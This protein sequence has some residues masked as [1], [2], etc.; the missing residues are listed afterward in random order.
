MLGR[1]LDH[2]F[3]QEYAPREIIVVD[4]GSEDETLE[5]A[6]RASQRGELEL[7]RSDRNRGC[8]SARNLGLGHAHGEIVAFIDADG[9]ANERWLGEVVRAFGEDPQVGGVASTVFFDDNPLVL[10]GAGG[11]VNRQGWAADLS[12][13]ESYEHAQLADEALYPMGCGMAVRRSAWERVGPFDD[14]MLNYYDDVDYGTRLWRAGYRVK[15]A[16]DAWIDH[17]AAAGDSARKRLLCERHRMRVVL[18]H[19][20]ARRITRWS[21]EEARSFRAAPLVAR[22]RKLRAATWNV[23]HLPSVLASRWRLRGAAFVP[24][25]LIDASWGDAFPVG[26][27]LRLH[28]DPQRAG[29]GIDMADADAAAQLTHGWFPPELVDGRS[30]R[31]AGPS[32][33][34]LIRLRTPV[35]QLRLDYAHVP[36]DIGGVD[37]CVR[38]SDSAEPLAAVWR[39]CLQ[40]QYIARTVE[41]HPLALA[42]G[43]YEV[44]FSTARGWSEPPRETRS[45]GFAL[46]AIAFLESL[47]ISPGNLDMASPGAE[48]HLVRG[49]FEAEQSAGHS[50]RWS[51]G[52]AALVVR[53]AEV[54]SQVRLRYRMAPAP[55]GDVEVSFTPVGSSRSVAGWQIAWRAGDWHDESFA[56]QLAPGDYVVSFAVATTWSNPGQ[57]DRDLP[58]ENRALGFALSAVAFD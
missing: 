36:V 12:M 27:A 1:C 33:A 54:T 22:L 34:A 35:S 4:D 8:P 25:R 7:L 3:A 32:A 21:L 16:P 24:R 18:K 47:D 13:N 9:F 19:A 5:V 20:P 39:T 38:R 52:R 57:Q 37:V 30:A 17:G 2:L 44:T 50:Y 43:E 48:Q 49:W 31:W 45:L 55:G 26:V 14:R 58:P 40:W 10:N 28:P 56:M 29:A 46:A 53:L 11:T 41:N 51:S 23:C 6:R 15:V 42:A